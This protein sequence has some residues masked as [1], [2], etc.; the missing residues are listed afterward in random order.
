MAIKARAGLW[1]GAISTERH[2]RYV[3]AVVGWL[4]ICFG[5]LALFHARAAFGSPSA[6]ATAGLTTLVLAA[7]AAFLLTRKSP[8][9]AGALLAITAVLF[10]VSVGVCVVAIVQNLVGGVYVAV[11]P[12]FWAPLLWVCWRALLAARFLQ[13]MKRHA[14]SAPPAF[15]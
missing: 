4:F 13:A 6:L 5:A 10:I 15:T 8:I 1:L 2:A 12:L 9:A 14:T 11:L 3:V 7:P